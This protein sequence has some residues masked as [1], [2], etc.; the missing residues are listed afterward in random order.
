MFSVLYCTPYNLLCGKSLY[1]THISSKNF[2]INIKSSIIFTKTG[3]TLRI[4]KSNNSAVVPW[5]NLIFFSKRNR[6]RPGKN[7]VCCRCCPRKDCILIFSGCFCIQW[8]RLLVGPRFRCA[9]YPD[10]ILFTPQHTG[11]PTA[12]SAVI[13]RIPR[14]FTAFLLC[15]C[16]KCPKQVQWVNRYISMVLMI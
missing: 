11:I 3:I 9:E 2:R 1:L 15:G 4:G 8:H 10:F 13:F 5:Q 16:K 14:K 7:F 6:N 12:I